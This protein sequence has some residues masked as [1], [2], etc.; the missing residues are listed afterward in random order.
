ML[1]RNSRCS[2]ALLAGVLFCAVPEAWAA[3]SDVSLIFVT[4]TQLYLQNSPGNPVLRANPFAFEAGATPAQANSIISGQ[5]T[6]PSGTPRTFTNLGGG[7]LFFDGGTF[8]TLAALNT[9]FPNSAATLYNFSLQT[10]TAP[11]AFSDSVSITNDQYPTN[12]PKI[13]SGTWSGGA[14]QVD[15]TQNYS[16]TWNDIAPFVLPNRMLLEILDAGGTTV[17]SQFFNPDPSG[18][19]INFTMPKGTLQPASFYTAKLTFERRQVVVNGPVSK[20]GT[21]AIETAFKIATIGA[22]PVVT[23]P[24]TPLGTVGQM[25]FYQIIASNNPF[26]FSASALPPGLTLNTTLGIISGIPTAPGNTAATLSAQNIDGVGTKNVTIA[27]Q[28]VPSSGPVII[29]STCA[30]AFAGKPFTFQVVTRGATQNARITAN[31]LPAGLILDSVTGKITGTTN[32]VGS[33]TVNLTVNDGGINAAGFLQ[34]TFT[35]DP[36]YPVIT[37]ADTVLLSKTQPFNYQIATPGATDPIDP[38]S[39]SLIGTL[40]QGLGFNEVTGVISGTY[41]GPV[42][43]TRADSRDTAPD[44]PTLSGGALLGS[45]QLFGTNSHGTSTFQLLFLAQPTGAVNISTRL[46]VG[47]GNNVMIAGFI[48]TG[49][50]PKVV[51]IRGIGPSLGIPGALQDPV[52][53]LHDS[54]GSAPVINDNWKATQEQ[55]IKDTTIPPT[56]DRESAIVIGLDPGNYTAILSGKNSSTGIGLIEV[57]DL[58]TASLDSGSKAQLA[59]I[60]TRGNVQQGDNVMIGGFIISGAT[61]NVIVRAIGPTLLNFGITNPLLD[62]TVELYNGSGTSLALNDDWRSTQEQA[63]KNTGVPPSDDRESAI[64]SSLVPGPY[65]AIVRGKNNA[66]GVALV[67]VYGLP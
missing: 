28:N 54:K 7:N 39:Y 63:I 36:G 1:R 45:V 30:Y 34:L 65:T 13:L 17:F 43:P 64:V 49:T 67:E 37:N 46:L 38:V 3:P 4:K 14:L 23:G 53:E 51:I 59:Q 9:A 56:D 19:N 2:V 6:P 41:T 27:I 58:G 44:A 57:Y 26:S 24:S 10:V 66:T 33:F 20:V 48:I 29:S 18:F 31:V 32:A 11:T 25:F 8:P 62:P 52:L 55:I 21:Y 5:F 50:A 22:V 12:I 40:P 42:P 15:A 35:P 61:T 47:T 60:S 16:F